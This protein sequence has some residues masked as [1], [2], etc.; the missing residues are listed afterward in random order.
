MSDTQIV[1]FVLT[2]LAL[3][4]VPGQDMVLVMSR[5]I[6]QGSKAGVATAVLGV[7]F[8]AFT[9]LVKGPV[10]YAAGA[11]SS[12]LR[13][14]RAVQVWLHRTSGCVLISLGIRLALEH[15]E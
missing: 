6:A 7:A 9:F 12:W 15:R 10:G 8:A 4:I 14:H 3:I 1:V 2:S 5:S 11:L 13:A